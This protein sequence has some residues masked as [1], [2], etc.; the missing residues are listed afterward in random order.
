MNEDISRSVLTVLQTLDI[1]ARSYSGRGMYGRSCVG[2]DC[3]RGDSHA[4]VAQIVI[5]LMS[6]KDADEEAAE[7]FTLDGAVATDS[8]GRGSIVYFPRLPWVEACECGDFG[9]EKPGCREDDEPCSEPAD[10]VAAL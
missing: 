1:E 2:V 7:H 6:L 9:C 10:S 4:V 3:A 5:G 8:M